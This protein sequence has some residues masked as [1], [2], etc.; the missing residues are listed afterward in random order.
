M[1]GSPFSAWVPGQPL[2]N[3]RQFQFGTFLFPL[4]F[5]EESREVKL[6]ADIRKIPFQYGEYLDWASSLTGRDI[7]LV[8]D[9]GS[10]LIGS[11]GSVLQTAADLEA[12]RA[13]LAGLQA[14]G[15]QQLWSAPDKFCWA[16]MMS[17]KHSFFKEGGAHRFAAW[18]LTFKAPDPRYYS[19]APN[20]FLFNSGSAITTN[21]LQT[22]LVTHLGSAR[23]YPTVTFV[24][25]MNV[26]VVTVSNNTTGQSTTL[27]FSGLIMSAGDRL[28]VI[29]DPRPENRRI[30]ALWT[31]NGGVPQNALKFVNPVLDIITNYDPSELLPWIG[32]ADSGPHTAYVSSQNTPCNYTAQILYYNT[33]L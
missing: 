30:C 22:Q 3:F 7:T 33:Y 16:Y 4:T 11:T 26:P 20:Q 19:A 5:Q 28:Q 12:E 17:F 32:T 10:G 8:G 13:V 6:A 9:V 1:P 25:V 21:T 29:C 15:L 27:R 31:P 14:K 2:I 24:G 18:T 23:A